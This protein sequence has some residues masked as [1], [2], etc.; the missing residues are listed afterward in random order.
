MTFLFE[1]NRVV[2]EI[3]L[4]HA[5]M[6]ALAGRP[7]SVRAAYEHAQGRAP[8]VASH[9]AFLAGATM[10]LGR[11]LRRRGRRTW[12]GPR[13][14][15]LAWSSVTYLVI[16]VLTREPCRGWRAITRSREL[17]HQVWPAVLLGKATAAAAWLVLLPLLIGAALALSRANHE[18]MLWFAAAV[19]GAAFFVG[20]WVISTFATIYRC[21]VYIFACEGVVPEPYNDPA[22]ATIWQVRGES[23]E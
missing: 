1:V 19:L 16:P 15:A 14:L 3:A 2:S 22:L 12:I 23:S 21:A 4:S 20:I 8:A 5:A 6:E 10:L 13:V 7:W 17:F 11:V 9:A 18:P